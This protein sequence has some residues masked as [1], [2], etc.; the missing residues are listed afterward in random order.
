MMMHDHEEHE[1]GDDEGGKEEQAGVCKMCGHP[2]HEGRT[3]DCGCT[4]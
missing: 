3:C 4:G 2:S 1:H